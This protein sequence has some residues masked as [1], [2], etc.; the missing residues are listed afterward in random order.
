MFWSR[1]IW[2]SSEASVCPLAESVTLKSV[3]DVFTCIKLVRNAVFF[4]TGLK[5]LCFPFS[6]DQKKYI[7]THA[8]TRTHTCTHKNML[9]HTDAYYMCTGPVSVSV[10]WPNCWLSSSFL[11]P[12]VSTLNQTQDIS[13]CTL[14]SGSQLSTQS[15]LFLCCLFV[16]L[17][18]YCIVCT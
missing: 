5:L 3:I 13:L 7:Q 9:I 15:I 4:A 10:T 18:F 6:C 12:T 1:E 16:C 2:K 11:P 14:L 17:C 8:H